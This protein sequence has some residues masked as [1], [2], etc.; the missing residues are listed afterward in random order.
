MVEIFEERI[1]VPDERFVA[2][3]FIDTLR[4]LR[5]VSACEETFAIAIERVEKAK[6]DIEKLP[7][8]VEFKVDKE[9]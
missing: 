7:T 1:A 9:S 6:C 2:Y 3:E 5:P 4:L 8:V